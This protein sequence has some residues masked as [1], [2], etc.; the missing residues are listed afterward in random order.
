[1]DYGVDVGRKTDLLLVPG[2]SL[3]ETVVSPS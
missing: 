1:M 2:E 3:A